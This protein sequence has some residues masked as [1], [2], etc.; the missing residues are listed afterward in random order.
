MQEEDLLQGQYALLAPAAL[1]SAAEPQ[2]DLVRKCSGLNPSARS[3]ADIEPE[4]VAAAHAAMAAATTAAAEPNK[5]GAAALTLVQPPTVAA[6]NLGE[7]EDNV[8]PLCSDSMA[9]ARPE[10]ELIA[11]QPPWAQAH[12]TSAL[13]VQDLDNLEDNMH[14][15]SRTIPRRSRDA[16]A[17]ARAAS[18]S[19]DSGTAGP[20]GR[21]GAGLA[22]RV[23]GRSQSQQQAAATKPSRVYRASL[24]GKLETA[25]MGPTSA[26]DAAARSAAGTPSPVKPPSPTAEVSQGRLQPQAFAAYL[27]AA[28]GSPVRRSHSDAQQQAAYMRQQPSLGGRGQSP[29]LLAAPAAGSPQLP[30]AAGDGVLARQRSAGT[31]R[32]QAGIAQGSFQPAEVQLKR[33]SATGSPY[34]SV[35]APA[36]VSQRQGLE[37]TPEPHSQN[38]SEVPQLL[39]AQESAALMSGTPGGRAAPAVPPKGAMVLQ[40]QGPP[41]W[42]LDSKQ[43]GLFLQSTPHAHGAAP[44]VVFASVPPNHPAAVTVQVDTRPHPSSLQA[45]PLPTT[46]S[47]GTD[48]T[49]SLQRA[50]SGRD[51]VEQVSGKSCRGMCLRCCAPRVLHFA[52]SRALRAICIC[53]AKSYILFLSLAQKVP[54]CLAA[55]VLP[56]V[57][58]PLASSPGLSTSLS[59]RGGDGS[60]PA[61]ATVAMLQQLPTVSA[62]AAQPTLTSAAVESLPEAVMVTPVTQQSSQPAHGAASPEASVPASLASPAHSSRPSAGAA[63]PVASASSSLASPA[64]TEATTPFSEVG[65]GQHG[66][67]AFQPPSPQ[68]ADLPE[69]QALRG[70]PVRTGS[71]RRRLQLQT[72]TESDE[73]AVLGNAARVASMGCRRSI[74]LHAPTALEEQYVDPLEQRQ[75]VR[76]HASEQGTEAAG[77][78]QLSFKSASVQPA[79]GQTAAIDVPA[80]PGAQSRQGSLRQRDVDAVLEGLLVDLRPTQV[81]QVSVTFEGLWCT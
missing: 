8:A 72:L 50:S 41:G 10:A 48:G 79:Q 39:K 38:H 61:G 34:S 27:T 23:Y 46:T 12:P 76:Q 24:S 13:G 47:A 5:L 59:G 66:A 33:Q 14:P 60:M 22:P 42:Q 44:V 3:T 71:S 15:F 77:T 49:C 51:S 35:R 69:E 62:T 6:S 73:P 70:S 1:Q 54:A 63:S 19:P 78:R 21:V 80:G 18:S 55:G 29:Q 11:H 4:L 28:P 81:S 67:A 56:R 25:I 52:K 37:P 40:A 30:A 65:V 74:E 36:V 9:A 31:R 43:Q 7:V 64:R 58:V 32:V 2:A 57:P 16:A 53:S 20:G 45:P 68:C 75:P 17:A 26:R